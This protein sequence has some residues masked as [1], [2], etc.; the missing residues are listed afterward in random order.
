VCRWSV[1]IMEAAGEVCARLFCC[2]G[3]V[4][5]SVVRVSTINHDRIVSPH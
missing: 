4:V 2:C 5:Q 3:S 1:G